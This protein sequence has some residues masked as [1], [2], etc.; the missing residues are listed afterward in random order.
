METG[1]LSVGR[2]GLELLGSN[3]APAWALQAAGTPAT[4]L[5]DLL[6]VHLLM[7][8]TSK[9]AAPGK[10]SILFEPEI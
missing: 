7:R 2:A 8:H 1:S 4:H 5:T 3:D 10:H 6:F 9:H